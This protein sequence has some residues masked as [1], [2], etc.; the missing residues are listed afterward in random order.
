MN[1]IE[2][3][4]L[5]LRLLTPDD[6]PDLFNIYSE[7]EVL[8][9]MGGSPGSLEDARKNIENHIRSYYE[10]RGFGLWGT[11]EKASGRLIGRCGILYQNVNGKFDAELAYLLD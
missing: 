6:A 9:F 7:T 1:V 2:T 5:I 10:A 11:V 3:E 8:K 4:R